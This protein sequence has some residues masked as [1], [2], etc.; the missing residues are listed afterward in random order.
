MKKLENAIIFKKICFVYTYHTFAIT[1][2]S[3]PLYRGLQ[4]FE[5]KIFIYEVK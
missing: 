5:N 1:L 2:I 4:I 3:P